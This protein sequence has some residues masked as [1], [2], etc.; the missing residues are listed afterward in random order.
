MTFIGGLYG[1]GYGYAAYAAPAVL[2]APV[3]AAAPVLSY[4]SYGFCY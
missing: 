4:R 1:Y 3:V 2:A